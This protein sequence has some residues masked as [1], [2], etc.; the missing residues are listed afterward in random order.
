MY[1]LCV[2]SKA[3]GLL[4]TN[5]YFIILIIIISLFIFSQIHPVSAQTKHRENFIL[6]YVALRNLGTMWQLY[7]GLLK[8]LIIIIL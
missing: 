3:F 6:V 8:L 7:R 4:E 1:L 5:K 2:S